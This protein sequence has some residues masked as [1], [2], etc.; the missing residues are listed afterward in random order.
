MNYVLHL[1]AKWSNALH[2][3]TIHIVYIYIFTL[4]ISLDVAID[5][6]ASTACVLLLLSCVDI[7][8]LILSKMRMLGCDVV[9]LDI[10]LINFAHNFMDFDRNRCIQ[11][12]PHRLR[13]YLVG[14]QAPTMTHHYSYPTMRAGC[15][16]LADGFV[17]GCIL[18]SRKRFI[19]SYQ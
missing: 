2:C 3:V 5:E 13:R 16:R 17:N 4:C 1:L 9:W 14:W 8:Y 19:M 11:L 18:G 6:I 7:S 10:T 15:Y 12:S